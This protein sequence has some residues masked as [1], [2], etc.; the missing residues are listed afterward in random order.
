MVYSGPVSRIQ[1][2]LGREELEH[3]DR[4]ARATGASRSELIRRAVTATYGGPSV[5]QKAAILTRTAGLWKDRKLTGAAYVDSV[6]GDLNRRLRR[7]GL[8]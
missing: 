7:V 6:R 5:E 2:Y 3:L 4:A 1:I 8:R